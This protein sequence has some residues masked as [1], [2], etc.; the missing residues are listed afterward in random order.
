MFILP[1]IVF[2]E[3][4]YRKLYIGIV[5]AP[6]ENIDNVNWTINFNEASYQN[7]YTTTF[8]CNTINML[9]YYSN[10][11]ITLRCSNNKTIELYLE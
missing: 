8:D 10:S 3:E 4:I 6:I 2:S 7:T 1:S 11:T 5:E 9:E